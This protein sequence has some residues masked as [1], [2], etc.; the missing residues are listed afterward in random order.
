MYDVKRFISLEISPNICF[1]NLQNYLSNAMK[2]ILQKDK[3]QLK[4]ILFLYN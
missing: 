4:Y 1:F 3:T 2:N